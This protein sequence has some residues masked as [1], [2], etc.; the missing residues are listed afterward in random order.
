MVQVEAVAMEKLRLKHVGEY[1]PNTLNS[2]SM[3]GSN[4][5]LYFVAEFLYVKKFVFLLFVKKVNCSSANIKIDS[6]FT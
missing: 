3:N 2:E 1:Q 4:R 6:L 5:I